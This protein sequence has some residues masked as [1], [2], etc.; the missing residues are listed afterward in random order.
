LL[1]RD[2]RRAAIS[3]QQQLLANIVGDETRIF[4][5]YTAKCFELMVTDLT[6]LLLLQRSPPFRPWFDGKIKLF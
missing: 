1:Y 2:A 6:M 3:T 4:V 5:S